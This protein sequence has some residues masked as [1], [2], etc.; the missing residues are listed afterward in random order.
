[1]KINFENYPIAYAVKTKSFPSLKTYEACEVEFLTIP[2][3]EILTQHTFP[4]SNVLASLN[5][6]RG[7]LLISKSQFFY[8]ILNNQFSLTHYNGNHPLLKLHGVFD[9]NGYIFNEDNAFFNSN[10]LQ[11]DLKQKD[12]DYKRATVELLFRYL[13][14]KQ[15]ANLEIYRISTNKSLGY[16]AK[17]LIGEEQYE[18]D[19]RF[20]VK[21]I[22]SK[23]IRTL[24]RSG[25]FK[26]R[27]FFRLQPCGPGFSKVKLIWINEHIR[28]KHNILKKDLK[29]NHLPL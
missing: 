22:D 16:Q 17:R 2:F 25:Q 5:N 8:E 19:F 15:F 28:N 11:A 14:F 6:Q 12:D 1:M 24:I 9:E 21:I 27:G 20:P 18:S 26:V 13:C 3:Y 7:I 10:L 29:A 23:Y 4:T